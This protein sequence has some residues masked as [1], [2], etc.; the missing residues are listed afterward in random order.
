VKVN[1]IVIIEASIVEART[2]ISIG[3][4]TLF[5]LKWATTLAITLKGVKST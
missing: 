3:V 5:L 4:K 1:G 2:P